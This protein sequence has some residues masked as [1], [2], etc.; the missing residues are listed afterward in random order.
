MHVNTSMRGTSCKHFYS[1]LFD[2]LPRAEKEACSGLKKMVQEFLVR[3]TI[4]FLNAHHAPRPQSI[5]FG[6][7]DAQV[8]QGMVATD[9]EM[10]QVGMMVHDLLT[11]VTPRHQFYAK[12]TWV[13][14]LESPDGQLRH[15]LKVIILN[16]AVE[17]EI[18]SEGGRQENTFLRMGAAT[19]R[20]TK[21]SKAEK[22]K[23]KKKETSLFQKIQAKGKKARKE[24]Q[25]A[26][27][28]E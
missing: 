27:N 12:V 6:V 1:S 18:F 22:K 16:L 14:V 11:T 21:M 28:N 5:S 24:K 15:V 4:A 10:D 19:W 8:V 26:D 23:T 25:D 7:T 9:K 13:P 2:F 20:L 3:T 17:Q